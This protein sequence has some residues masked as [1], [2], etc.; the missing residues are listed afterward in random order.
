MR[1]RIIKIEKS[2]GIILPESILKQCC[3]E[4]EVSIEV[5]N[6]QIV[7]SK[8]E[9]NKRKGWEQAFKEMAANGDDKLLIPDLFKDEEVPDWT[10]RK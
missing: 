2:S 10:F 3:I 7:I 4:N 9:H 8:H 6:F 5:K 1:S